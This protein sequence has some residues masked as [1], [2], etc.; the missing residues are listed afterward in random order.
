MSTGDEHSK[1]ME[2][3]ILARSCSIFALRSSIVI[4][5][6]EFSSS[7]SGGCSESSTFVG[8]MACWPCSVCDDEAKGSS[9]V[10]MVQVNGDACSHDFGLWLIM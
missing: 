8:G 6:V 5:A 3:T 1:Y 9:S 2:R 7:F 10:D 4:V